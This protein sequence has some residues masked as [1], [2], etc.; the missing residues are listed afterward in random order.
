MIGGQVSFTYIISMIAQMMAEIES[1]D[2]K[3]EEKLLILNRIYREYGLD[4]KLYVKLKQSLRYKFTRDLEEVNSFIDDLPQNLKVETAVYIH[5]QT[6]NQIN[7][8]KSRSDTF[9]SWICPLLKP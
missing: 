2:K 8:F 4:M 5:S 3:F 1:S 9:I 7:F 6:W